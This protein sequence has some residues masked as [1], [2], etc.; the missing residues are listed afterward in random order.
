MNAGTAPMADEEVLSPWEEAASDIVEDHLL[1]M[2]DRY[3]ERAE[4]CGCRNCWFDAKKWYDMW[5]GADKTRLGMV[6]E[7]LRNG[8]ER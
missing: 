4:A 7:I 2:V 1:Q 5:A 6:P 3:V 8:P